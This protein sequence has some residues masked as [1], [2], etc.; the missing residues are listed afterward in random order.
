VWVGI[1]F[2]SLR[3]EC[4]AT[5]CDSVWVGI[6]F[7]PPEVSSLSFLYVKGKGLFTMQRESSYLWV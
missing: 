2:P 6:G 4:S 5:G 1:G 3:A 7:P